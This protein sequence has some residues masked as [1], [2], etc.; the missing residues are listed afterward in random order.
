MMDAVK[1]MKMDFMKMK[2]QVKLMALVVVVVIAF[3][4]KMMGETMGVWSNM[5]MIFMGIILCAVP[6]S[7]DMMAA[8]GFI[9]LLPAQAKQRVFGRYMFAAVFLTACAVLGG[10]VSFPY[11]LKGQTTVGYILTHGIIFL[12][13]GLCINSLQYMFSYFFEIKNQQWLSIIRL[14]PG[15]IFFFGGSIL[16][17][18][19]GDVQGLTMNRIGMAL[20]Y[21]MQHQGM[22]ATVFLAAAVIFTMFCAAV[23]GKREERKEA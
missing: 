10:L 11:L 23:C 12:S 13:V 7:I 6:F 8:D 22:V 5:Y 1:F 9:K 21:A 3:G 14:I 4:G 18:A 19:I 20:N 17:D 2:T 16:F 15:F